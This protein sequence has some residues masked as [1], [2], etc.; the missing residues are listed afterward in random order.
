MAALAGLPRRGLWIVSRLDGDPLGY[1][2]MIE[3]FGAIYDRA[4]IARPSKP[5]HCLRHTFG[6]VPWQRTAA[7]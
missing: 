3:A 7:T 2:G 4:G 5:I 6:T 1:F